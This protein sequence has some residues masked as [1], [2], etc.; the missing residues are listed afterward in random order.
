MAAIVPSS[1][2]RYQ[3]W[4]S[5]NLAGFVLNVRA[6]FDSGY[7]ALHRADCLHIATHSNPGASTER[8][9][10]KVCATSLQA[11]QAWARAHGRPDG[12]FTHFCRTCRPH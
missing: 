11:L 8:D 3:T 1:D 4:R 9:Y 7:M 2:A 6:S 12:T 5:S 10:R